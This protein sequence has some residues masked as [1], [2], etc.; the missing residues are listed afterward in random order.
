MLHCRAPRRCAAFEQAGDCS[1]LLR[2]L[3]LPSRGLASLRCRPLP[4]ASSRRG[5]SIVADFDLVCG[6]RWLVHVQQAAFFLALLAGAVG[7]QMS[8][9][10]YGARLPDNCW[11][12]AL[13]GWTTARLPGSAGC[14]VLQA[15]HH[16]SQLAQ[17]RPPHASPVPDPAGRRR[18]LY[19][20]AALAGLSAACAS[21]AP[22]L[23]T[24][25]AFRAASGVGVGGMGAAAFALA[26]DLAGPAWRGWAGLLINHFFSGGWVGGEG[27]CGWAVGLG[28]A[29][30]GGGGGHRRAVVPETNGGAHSTPPQPPPPR[31]RRVRGD[32]AGL[33]GALL[34]PAHLPHR[35]GLPGLPGHLVSGHRVA[36][37]AAAARQEGACARAGRGLGLE[38]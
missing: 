16:H 33:V 24:Y 30:R 2:E 18:L 9:E 15:A 13:L 4:P 34:A 29:S 26:T 7:W 10:R 3:A 5:A 28:S 32:A 31:S 25:L 37:V 20:G 21:T 23:L 6:R 1:S 22:S 35:P 17:Q 8:A 12:W 38:L 11:D 27:G 36:A 19:A 14:R